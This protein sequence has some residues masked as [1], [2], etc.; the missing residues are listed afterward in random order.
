MSLPRKAPRQRRAHTKNRPRETID[1][2]GLQT[3]QAID[4]EPGVTRVA[5]PTFRVHPDALADL[6]DYCEEHDIPRAVLMR[7]LIDDFLNGLEE[8]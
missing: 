4:S 2:S 3:W 8:S 5:F 1:T 6:N 7:K